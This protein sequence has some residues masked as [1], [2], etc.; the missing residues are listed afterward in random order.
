MIVCWK[1]PLFLIVANDNQVNY[2][3]ILFIMWF[4]MLIS[5]IK[6]IAD[7]SSSLWY[8]CVCAARLY[9][10]CPILPSVFPNWHWIGMLE[11]KVFCSCDWVALL[12]L[13]PLVC[14]VL[15]FLLVWGC[16]SLA[17]VLLVQCRCWSDEDA[18]IV[19]GSHI[20]ELLFF[21]KRSSIYIPNSP[22][23][24][25]IC[26][27]CGL[28]NLQLMAQVCLGLNLFTSI[29]SSAMIPRYHF[30]GDFSSIS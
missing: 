9:V 5:V 25:S 1:L 6:G 29:H 14:L 23:Q 7:Q 26:W 28:L 18:G 12:H 30:C 13:R 4:S 27:E 8:Q 21:S 20:R 24:F 22:S 3:V 10:S 2:S 15:V 16:S 17:N 19:C 11:W